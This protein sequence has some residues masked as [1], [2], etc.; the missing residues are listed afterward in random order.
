MAIGFLI[1][2]CETSFGNWFRA[3]WLLQAQCFDHILIWQVFWKIRQNIACHF[4]WKA[5]YNAW[6]EKPCH[7][8][9]GLHLTIFFIFLFRIIAKL[10]D[11]FN[12]T[13]FFSYSYLKL[14]QNYLNTSIWRNFYEVNKKWPFH[15]HV[16]RDIR[17]TMEMFFLLSDPTNKPL[18]F[19]SR[20]SGM[21]ISFLKV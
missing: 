15:G 19:T 10:F 1:M 13:I 12:L 6:R 8:S 3:F 5:F 21:E 14:L 18:Q 20:A 4:T 11:Y 2:L 16:S 7:G 9:T 17:R